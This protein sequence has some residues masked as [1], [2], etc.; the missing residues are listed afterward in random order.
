MFVFKQLWDAFLD[1][2]NIGRVCRFLTL[3][4]LAVFEK[5]EIF[6]SNIWWVQKY[7]LYLHRLSKRKQA[8][9]LV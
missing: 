5:I 6:Y 2:I 4:R 3:P 8:G 9:G 1:S 7:R